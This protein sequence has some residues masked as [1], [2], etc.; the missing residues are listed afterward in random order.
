[1]S[2]TTSSKK[3]SQGTPAPPEPENHPDPPPVLGV[4]T[5]G[6]QIL[7]ETVKSEGSFTIPTSMGSSVKKMFLELE[8]ES[9][10][11]NDTLPPKLTN[12]LKEQMQANDTNVKFFECTSLV[13]INEIA[14]WGSQDIDSILSLF[15]NQHD[16]KDFLHSI[17]MIHHLPEF[18][19]LKGEEVKSKDFQL[20][21]PSS[22]NWLD[23]LP[24]NKEEP[25]DFVKAIKMDELQCLIRCTKHKFMVDLQQAMEE[26]NQGSTI[27]SRRSRGDPKPQSSARDPAKSHQREILM[28]ATAQSPPKT[29]ET[30]GS[31]GAT[32]AKGVPSQEPCP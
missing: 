27:S 3:T 19:K 17:V 2:T 13:T 18:F 6:E 22:S 25:D 10:W 24:T 30:G 26:F 9:D 32:K 11:S 29:A 28:A 23:F 14:Q 5:P 16:D 15:P 12:F 1:M 4:N 21:T 8:E 7:V 31:T 20:L